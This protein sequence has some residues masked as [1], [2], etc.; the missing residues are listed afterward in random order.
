M[1]AAA[2][3]EIAQCENCGGLLKPAGDDW[4]HQDDTGCTDLGV[5]VLCV[6]C[7]SPAAVGC[8]ACGQCTGVFFCP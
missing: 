7:G 2:Q 4:R 8:L 1:T 3:P 5:P 6:H